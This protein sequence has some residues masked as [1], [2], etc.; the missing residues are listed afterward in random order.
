MFAKSVNFVALVAVALTACMTV[1]ATHWCFCESLGTTETLCIKYIGGNW[2]GGSC[3]LDTDTKWN[4]FKGI[5]GRD[6]EGI[7]S[8]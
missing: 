7:T 4:N 8:D 5:C 2:D 3:G 1:E 6:Y